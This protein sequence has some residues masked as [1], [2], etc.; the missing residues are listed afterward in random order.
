MSPGYTVTLFI[1][2]A[3]LSLA[4]YVDRVYS[5]MGKFLAR[6]YQD[7][8]DAWEEVVEPRL[9]L[10]RESIALSAS[11]LRH[12]AVFWPEAIY[13]DEF[14]TFAGSHSE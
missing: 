13:P 3:I 12:C 14:A 2:L 11:V 9:L 10:G 8:I 6:E 1:L 5:E 7:N 4:A